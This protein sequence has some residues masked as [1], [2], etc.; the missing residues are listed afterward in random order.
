MAVRRRMKKESVQW[1]G[2]K[3]STLLND[4][5][6]K[7]SAT[8]SPFASRRIF[9]RDLAAGFHGTSGVNNIE[10]SAQRNKQ[11]DQFEQMYRT[12]TNVN[13]E[14]NRCK[15]PFNYKDYKFGE[16]S[17]NSFSQPSVLA[18]LA[19]SYKTRPSGGGRSPDLQVCRG[20]GEKANKQDTLAKR[21]HWR[22]QASFRSCPSPWWGAM[23]RS[24]TI[25]KHIIGYVCKWWT[26]CKLGPLLDKTVIF[27]LSKTMWLVQCFR[28]E[29]KN[30]KYRQNPVF[31]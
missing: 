16:S 14:M 5:V 18:F 10:K 17:S 12:L 19:A 22:S 2:T 8:T 25:C 29:S 7:I 26:I 15:M 1:L 31:D 4:L 9:Q 6:K 24:S 27:N 11:F 28:K 20:A 23:R 30:R 13:A 21:S 3:T